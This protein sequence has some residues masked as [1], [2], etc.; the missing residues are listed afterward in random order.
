MNTLKTNSKDCITEKTFEYD[1][2]NQLSKYT[3]GDVTAVY[4]YDGDNLRRKKSVE[5]PSGVNTVEHV[6]DGANVVLDADQ[7]RDKNIYV[8]GNGLE[9]FKDK[10]G[11]TNR[12]I[13]SY[14]GDVLSDSGKS[15][16]TYDAFCNKLKDTEK[17][18]NPFE[19]CGEYFDDE[20]ALTYLIN[21]YYDPELGRFI[22]ENPARDGLNWYVYANSVIQKWRLEHFFYRSR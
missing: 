3:S 12:Y 2:F 14:K 8:F 15:K 7:T 4:E 13:T 17:S 19:Y 21:R 16:Y 18:E 20:K 5:T 9:L 22:S 10:S 11:N 6:C 1:V